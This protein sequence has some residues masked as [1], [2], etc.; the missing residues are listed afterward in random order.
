MVSLCYTTFGVLYAHTAP[1]VVPT[2]KKV[3]VNLGGKTISASGSS[4]VFDVQ[5]GE[6]VLE[7]GTV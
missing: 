6:L 1:I 2:G 3:T 4:R 5:G 7:N